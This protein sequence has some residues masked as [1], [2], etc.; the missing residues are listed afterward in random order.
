MTWLLGYHIGAVRAC[1]KGPGLM[2][3]V[4]GL[5]RRLSSQ[6]LGGW[7]MKAATAGGIQCTR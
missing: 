2:L 3:T 1:T 6:G 7:V 4:A 5:Y